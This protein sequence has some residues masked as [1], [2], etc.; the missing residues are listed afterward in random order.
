ME[1]GGSDRVT[2]TALRNGMDRFLGPLKKEARRRSLSWRLIPC[3][4]REAT[5]R[6]FEN[7]VGNA[8]PSVLKVLLV[9]SEGPVRLPPRAHLRDR[10]C[11]DLDF[12][13]E[14]TIHLMVQVMESWIVA[15]PKALA[16]YY[17]QGFNVRK[18]PKRPDLEQEPKSRVENALKQ[19][20]KRTRKGIY[21]KIKHASELLRLLDHARVKDR[22]GHC[23]RLFDV[24][25]GIIET[26]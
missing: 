2:K 19:A 10:D 3:G 26:A 15:D 14:D 17:G 24:L 12:A 4:S 9:D 7:A 18:L 20:T 16:R 13:Q 22:C 11:W 6:E 1:G 23:K 5:Y 8:D 21:H 25:D